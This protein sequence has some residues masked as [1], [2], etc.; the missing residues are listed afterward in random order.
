MLLV[1]LL[2]TGKESSLSFNPCSHVMS[3]FALASNVKNGVQGNKCTC[4]QNTNVKGI[5][6]PSVKRLDARCVYTFNI[7]ML[8]LQKS[9]KN[10][11]ADVTW[12]CTLILQ[13]LQCDSFENVEC[14]SKW[15]IFEFSLNVLNEFNDKNICH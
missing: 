14:E 1:V 2:L 6:T 13:A 4:S 9:K 10:G 11:N 3:A 7:C 15:R 12:E 5:N 8:G